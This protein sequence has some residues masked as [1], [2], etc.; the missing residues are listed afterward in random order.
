MK[1]IRVGVVDQGKEEK[2][3][4]FLDHIAAAGAEAVVLGWRTPKD[5]AADAA[6]FDALV[7]CGGDDVDAR[8]W[9][10][11]NHPTVQ[12]VPSERDE[13]EI[14]FARA[15]VERGVPLLGVCRGS[16]VMN[17]AMGG[18]LEQH[19]PDVPGRVAHGDGARH[20]VEV[21]PGTLLARIAGRPRGF[22]NSFH[23]QAVGRLAPGLRV[24]ARSMDGVVEAV[25]GPGAF[26]LGVQWHPERDGC[27]ESLGRALFGELV[28]AASLKGPPA[29][30]RSS[31][32]EAGRA[33]D[34]GRNSA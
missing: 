16:Q 30:A 23:H 22:V 3:R 31:N 17:V 5:A 2:L 32:G 24:A 7:L 6:S 13:Y 1:R 26:C 33:G 20:E 4:P 25:E 9:G 10:E 29:P 21:S 11:E 18:T 14:A 19:V 28:R 12:L 27:D 15:A 8:R 34:Q